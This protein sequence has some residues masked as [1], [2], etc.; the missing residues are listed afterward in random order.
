M[1]VKL[2]KKFVLLTTSISILVLVIIATAINTINYSSVHNQSD[3][4]I[5][6]L[7]ENNMVLN[8]YFDPRKNLSREILFTTR[9][10]DVAFDHKGNIVH[11]N[12]K[13]IASVSPEKAV[14]YAKQVYENSSGIIDDFK[15]V[16]SSTENGT[17]IV[18]LD[19]QNQLKTLKDYVFYSVI[20]V[21][22]SI[23]LIFALAVILS[24]KAVEPIVQS[25]ERQKGFI[26][27]VSH[28]F[29]TP[30]AIIRADCD[31]LELDNT[32]TEWTD[33][34]KKQVSRLDTLVESL[35]SLTKLDEKVRLVKKNFCLSD[36]LDEVLSDFS[37]SIISANIVLT[38]EIAKSISYKGDEKLIR[39]LM[40]TLIE[41]A[42]K[43]SNNELKVSLKGK[44]L[45]VEN[46][47]ED[48]SIG[49][50]SQWFERFHRGDA[51]RN[52]KGFGIGLS[53]AK[54][55]CSIHGAKILAKSKTGK[56]V[57]IK[58]NF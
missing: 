40:A 46:S 35:I 19:I 16:V 14:L 24:K 13:N 23:F 6:L 41:N 5:H 2:Q 28:E 51:S 17:I 52:S 56:D 49:K 38:K 7:I 57:I 27:N 53:V 29:K 26:T 36:A 8:E 22:T 33:S 39:E 47:C 44:V 4:I 11:S 32:E 37:S 43:Y 55:I 50:H 25:F 12:T 58:V 20:V 10:F 48:I 9:F 1:F 18:F 54:T 34:I 15:Y 21:L 3:E 31:V 30:L 42:I 45:I